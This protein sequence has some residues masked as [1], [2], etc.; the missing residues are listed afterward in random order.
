MGE[1]KQ[2][3]LLTYDSCRKVI[4]PSHPPSYSVALH[5]SVPLCALSPEIKPSHC[6]ANMQIT[7]SSCHGFKLKL[8]HP[9]IMAQNNLFQKNK[10]NKKIAEIKLL[11]N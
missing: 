7:T 5:R 6:Y 2:P 1:K 3:S 11:G 8:L 10:K 9:S 4:S